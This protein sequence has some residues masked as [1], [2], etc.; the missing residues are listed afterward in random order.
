MFLK[1]RCYVVA[2]VDVQLRPASGVHKYRTSKSHTY[3]VTMY[4]TKNSKL[5]FVIIKIV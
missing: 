3:I 5:T 4:L 1:F 2:V